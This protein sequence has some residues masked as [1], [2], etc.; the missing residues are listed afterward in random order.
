M[1]GLFTRIEI[2]ENIYKFIESNKIKNSDE[3]FKYYEKYLYDN[4]YLDSDKKEE[5]FFSIPN[6]KIFEMMRELTKNIRDQNFALYGDDLENSDRD[7]AIINQLSNLKDPYFVATEYEK[8]RVFNVTKEF[9]V[10]MFQDSLKFENNK[11]KV[12]DYLRKYIDF[13]KRSKSNE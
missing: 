12:L 11:D 7:S 1:N 13:Y 4:G 9:I 10:S 8:I 6:V 5:L 2:L 3:I